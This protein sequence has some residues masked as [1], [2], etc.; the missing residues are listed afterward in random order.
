MCGFSGRI[1]IGAVFCPIGWAEKRLSCTTDLAPGGQFC[2]NADPV[3]TGG[4]A[5]LSSMGKEH[6]QKSSAT[7]GDVLYAKSKAPVSEQDWVRLVQSIAAG[8]ERA[9]HALYERAH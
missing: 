6:A 5:N 4:L 2:K 9:L 1:Q 8:E 7:L 3:V